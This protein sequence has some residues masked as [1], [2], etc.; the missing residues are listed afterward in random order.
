MNQDSMVYV[1]REQFDAWALGGIAHDRHRV[2]RIAGAQDW[3]RLMTPELEDARM[4]ADRFLASDEKPM[5]PMFGWINGVCCTAT[6]E[7]MRRVWRERGDGR[8]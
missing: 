7:D 1:V 8:A 6:L 3:H 4:L 5:A 2:Q